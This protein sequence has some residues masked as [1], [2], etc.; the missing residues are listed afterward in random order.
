LIASIIAIGLLV[1]RKSKDVHAVKTEWEIS[2]RKA[3]SC[4]RNSLDILVGDNK[5]VAE[6]Q[7]TK[8]HIKL[9]EQQKYV[10]ERYEN[11]NFLKRLI[12]DTKKLSKYRVYNEDIIS[13]HCYGFNSLSDDKWDNEE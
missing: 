10:K 3:L 7:Y 13:K 4:L 12:I 9:K 8:I 11:K 1:E 6:N 5:K 2:N